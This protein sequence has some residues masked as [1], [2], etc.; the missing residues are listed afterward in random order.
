MLKD[1]NNESG[2]HSCWR[3]VARKTW[4]TCKRRTQM[5]LWG[6]WRRILQIICKNKNKSAKA[7]G[8][9]LAAFK[10]FSYLIIYSAYINLHLLTRSISSNSCRTDVHR[11]S[12]C[13]ENHTG[14]CL[15]NWRLLPPSHGREDLR[16]FE[17][18]YIILLKSIHTT[19]TLSFRV[20][21]YQ[22]QGRILNYTGREGKKGK[23]K[24]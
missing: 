22:A 5:F 24:V 13:H 21:D 7:S 2:S 18:R 15:R 6:I 8:G 10:N 23:K 16:L 20:S 19:E 12:R 14:W 17:R 4:Q 3:V 1:T 9:L 11:R